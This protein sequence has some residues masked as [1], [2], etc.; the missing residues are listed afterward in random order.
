MIKKLLIGGL[1]AIVVIAAAVSA[2]NV[3]ASQTSTRNQVAQASTAAGQAQADQ[4]WGQGSANGQGIQG[5][6]GRQGDNAQSGQGYR[7]GNGGSGNG[8]G[9]QG[10]G[11]NGQGGQGSQGR[12]GNG[13]GGGRGQ[14]RQGGGSGVPNP[15]NGLTEWVTLNGVVSSFAAPNLTLATDDGQ[16]ITVQLGSASYVSSIGLSLNEGD[17]VTL[18]GFYETDGTF[19][20]GSITITATGQTFTLRDD[21]GRPAWRGGNN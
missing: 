3:F 21:L 14:G 4:A 8:Q 11:G 1:L 2:Y 18:T 15:Q 19:A 5:S 6:Q 16:T 17:A 9:G 20:V 10:R 13:Q 7:G 12:G